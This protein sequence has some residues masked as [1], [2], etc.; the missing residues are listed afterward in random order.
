MTDILRACWRQ[1]R[2]GRRTV[3]VHAPSL[4]AMRVGDVGERAAATLNRRSILEAVSRRHRGFAMRSNSASASN[5]HDHAEPWVGDLIL[6]ARA[7]Q[8]S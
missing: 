7:R 6:N 8:V 4:A 3:L 1:E 2:A 5:K